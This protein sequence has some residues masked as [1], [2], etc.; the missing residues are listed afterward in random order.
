MLIVDTFETD[1]FI[2]SSSSFEIVTT[3][4]IKDKP[5]AISIKYIT[6]CTKSIGSIIRL[7]QYSLK[8]TILLQQSWL[9]SR[10]STSSNQSMWCT[11]SSFTSES[12][13][14]ISTSSSSSK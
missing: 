4:F 11:I 3:Q 5:N 12:S 8:S 6:C 9:E 14:R 1:E 13:V 2:N 7:S 10:M